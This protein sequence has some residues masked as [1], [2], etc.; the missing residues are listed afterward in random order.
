MCTN[1]ILSRIGVSQAPNTHISRNNIPLVINQ[2]E[3]GERSLNSLAS[4]CSNQLIQHTLF[5]C[6]DSYYVKSGSMHGTPNAFIHWLTDTPNYY[7]EKTCH[8]YA[9][10]VYL[11]N[12]GNK[13]AGSS[14]WDLRTALEF[15]K[16]ITNTI[17]LVN[18]DKYYRQYEGYLSH[19]RVGRPIEHSIDVDL[20]Y[21]RA[22]ISREMARKCEIG[23][24]IRVDPEPDDIQTVTSDARIVLQVATFIAG[25]GQRL[26][27]HL[28][29]M[30]PAKV[31]T[32][33]IKPMI[34]PNLNRITIMLNPS[35]ITL[36]D[37]FMI[38]IIW[39]LTSCHLVSLESRVMLNNVM[40]YFLIKDCVRR[41]NP[42]HRIYDDAN[43]PKA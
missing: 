29:A 9:E 27:M 33:M 31:Y 21:V 26:L 38:P 6:K 23:L 3:L 39:F 2:D 11:S 10:E 15:M 7:H 1:L 17:Y 42:L 28:D 24:E 37:I 43:N 34:N 16:G 8:L 18:S 30:A 35:L 36:G 22:L 13:L 32:A 12:A 40:A 5:M 4:K 19:S 14:Y 41:N 20:F 25:E